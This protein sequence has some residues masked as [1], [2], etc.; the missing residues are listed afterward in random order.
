MRGWVNLCEAN[1][2]NS[3]FDFLKSRN[4][5]ETNTSFQQNQNTNKLRPFL[6]QLLHK[7]W[8]IPKVEALSEPCPTSKME[9]FAVI[10]TSRHLLP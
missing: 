8:L 7:I 5:P 3:N 6:Q 9:F 2:L 4:I 10:V 1:K